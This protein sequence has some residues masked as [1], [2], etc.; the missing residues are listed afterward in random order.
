MFQA[1]IRLRDVRLIRYV[2]ASVAALAVDMGSF[3]VL[4][5]ASMNAALAAASGYSAGI[6][7]HWLLSSRAVFHDGLAARGEGRGRQKVLFV[8]SAIV[9][10]GLTTAIVALGSQAG[11]DPRGSKLAAIVISFTVTYL[12]RKTVVFAP[13][14]R[15]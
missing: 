6:L 10:L 5:T 3:L 2:L 11:L 14:E 15:S 13:A 8:G 4:L 9:G 7:V 1:L 12:L